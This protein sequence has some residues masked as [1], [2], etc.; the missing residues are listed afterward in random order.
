[1]KIR[2]ILKSNAR[3]ITALLLTVTLTGLTACNDKDNPVPS[4]ELVA[5]PGTSTRNYDLN[6]KIIDAIDYEALTDVF[7][8]VLA[9]T[10]VLFVVEYTS[11]GPDLKTPVRL[12]GGICMPMAVYKYEQKPSCLTIY[13]QYTTTQHD[14]RLTKF[15]SFDMDFF[16]NKTQ[17]Q[18]LLTSNLYGWTL[19][20][21]KPQAY[22]CGEVTA[23]ETLDFYDAATQVLYDVGYDLQGLPLINIGYSSGGYSA[24]AVQRFIDEKRPDL[25]VT[26]TAAGG[27][28]FD[29]NTVY[30]DQVETNTTGYVCSLPLMVV[31]YK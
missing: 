5:T 28:P 9:T 8:G 15:M 13:N 3:L 11:V 6:P 2:Q 14:E 25:H 19:T 21:D 31:A 17:N 18:I 23:I 22:C 27:A 24:M 1:M 10:S 30:H 4:T 26:L 16:T 20:E 7:D 12:T 29:I